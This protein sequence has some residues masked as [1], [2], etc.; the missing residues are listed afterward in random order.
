[1]AP[2][3]RHRRP[4]TMAITTEEETEEVAADAVEA[5]SEETVAEEG[6]TRVDEAVVV[7]IAVVD[8]TG[9]VAVAVGTNGVPCRLLPSSVAKS[10]SPRKLFTRKKASSDSLPTLAILSLISLAVFAGSIVVPYSSNTLCQCMDLVAIVRGSYCSQS[11]TNCDSVD[12]NVSRYR[13]HAPP[14][15]LHHEKNLRKS[16]KKANKPKRPGL[17]CPRCQLRLSTFQ[18]LL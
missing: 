14:V 15:L 7:D 9:L 2:S 8:R 4:T 5:A 1:V 16:S 12:A 10:L 18:I 11:N 6:G 17:C 13:A 3:V